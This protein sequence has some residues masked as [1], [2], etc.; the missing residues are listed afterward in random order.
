[1]PPPLPPSRETAHSAHRTPARYP[2]PTFP[3]AALVVPTVRVTSRSAA[4][5]PPNPEPVPSP[6][7]I[8]SERTADARA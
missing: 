1:V 8:P 6:E 5:T 4:V 2:G 3:R 7:P